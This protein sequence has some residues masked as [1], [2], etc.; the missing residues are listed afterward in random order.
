MSLM[1]LAGKLKGDLAILYS[2]YIKTYTPYKALM[3][4]RADLKNIE[5]AIVKKIKQQQPIQ[6][7]LFDLN[8]FTPITANKHWRKK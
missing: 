2:K 1:K 4:A 8:E 5:P 7:S 3:M 6:R